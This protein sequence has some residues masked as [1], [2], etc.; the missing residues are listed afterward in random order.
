MSNDGAAGNSPVVSD[1]KWADDVGSCEAVVSDVADEI[2]REI[3]NWEKF[4]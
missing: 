3:I 2:G 1:V 4:Y